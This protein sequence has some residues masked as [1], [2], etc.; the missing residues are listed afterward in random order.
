VPAHE[1]ADRVVVIVQARMGSTRL[2][3]KVL[4]PLGG[5]PVLQHVVDRVRASTAVDAVVVATTVDRCDDEVAHAA[6]TFGAGVFRGSEADVL[7][8][9]AG[10]ASAFDAQLIVR[11]TA[12]CPLLDTDVLS[13]MLT[14]M[15]NARAASQPAD[16]LTNARV[17]TYPRGLDIEIFTRAALSIAASEAAQP[18]EREHVTPFFYAHPDRFRIVDHLAPADHSRFRLTLDTS[19]DYDL[20]SAI[21]AAQRAE[22]LGLDAVVE[23]LEAHPEWVRLNASV[24]QKPT[25][26]ANDE[27]RV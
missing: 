1:T 26:P 12:D 10:A 15:K 22:P 27:S 19:E 4:M 8:R 5:R 17:R 3:G 20:L 21:F 24:Q 7:A 25:V 9:Y 13:E 6:T 11:I 14:R 18:H 16:L 2:P 23:L